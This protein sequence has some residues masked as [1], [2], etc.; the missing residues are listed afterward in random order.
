MKQNIV[1]YRPIAR[2]RLGKHIPAGANALN[3]MTSIARQRISKH[4]S[5]TIEA[6]FCVVRAKWLWESVK[7]CRTEVES[8]FETPACQNMSLGAEELNW[9]DNNCKKWIRL[10]KEDFMCDLK[11]QWD[12]YKSVARIRLVKTVDPSVCV[13]VNCKVCRQAIAL[14]CL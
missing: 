14:Y 4:A 11:S 8:S 3:N 12:G 13:T 1:T 9:V 2:Q 10:W 6:V 7:Q 5:L